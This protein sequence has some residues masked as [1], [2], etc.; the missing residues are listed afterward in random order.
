MRNIWQIYK[1][2]IKRIITNPVALII[3]VGLCI[4]PSLYA[5]FNIYA[6]WDP[7]GNTNGVKVA[8]VNK[9]E[10]GILKEEK[11]NIGNDIVSELK[12]NNDI[13]WIFVDEDEAEYGLTHNKYYASIQIPENFTSDILTITTDEKVKPQLIYKVNE[14]SNAIAPKITSAG[15]KALLK[16]VTATFVDKVN[17][18]IFDAFNT[19][20]EEIDTN[21]SKILSVRD[22]VYKLNDNLDEIENVL[23]KADEGIITFS[24]FAT[25]VN[26]SVPKIK[27]SL[28]EA[29]TV[30][31]NVNTLANTGREDFEKT[32]DLV[33]IK[34]L[35][36]EQFI[37]EFNSMLKEY[38]DNRGESYKIEELIAS[39]NDKVK[40]INTRLDSTISFLEQMN[41]IS[42]KFDNALK[43]LNELKASVV[44]VQEKLDSIS[45]NV[46]AGFDFNSRV[47]EALLNTGNDISN[48]INTRISSF[49]TEVKPLV[50][51]IIS[52]VV[53]VSNSAN[54]LLSSAEKQIPTVEN[55]LA[56]SLDASAKGKSYISEF[57]EK[58]P[59]LKEGIQSLTIKL[60]DVASDENI[61][62]IISILSNDSSVM[63]DFIS[64]PVELVEE[65]V[66]HIPNYGSAM[67][68]FYSILSIWVGVLLLS[69]IITTEVDDLDND[70]K[71]SI[72]QKYFGRML[73]FL[74]LGLIQSL[75]I[76][77]GD[78]YFLGVSME[79]T[80]LF[81]GFSLFT[82]VIFVLILY[83]LVSLL[84]NVGKAVGV[85]LL[86]LQVAGS[87]GTFPIEVTPQFF[88]KL[89]PFLPFT[90]SIGALREAVGGP[91]WESVYR[92]GFIMLIYG[93]VA[94]LLGVVLKRWVNG[95]VEKLQHKFKES[96]LSE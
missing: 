4:L 14:K 19:L 45:N 28:A 86:V 24:E 56:L 93:V 30:S 62:Q 42:G 38:I 21:K 51:E 6:S 39:L 36:V 92:D 64:S 81:I 5:W 69:S 44:S 53:G 91:T 89:Q 35:E 3:I 46:G 71:P 13:G 47:L 75:I 76:S 15:T 77:V 12:N 67:S 59:E 17:G 8:I 10:G 11:L 84:G 90:Y 20:G 72:N 2:D 80:G 87:G 73:L 66:F 95:P 49:K 25:E 83:T 61:N 82:S 31:N 96:G 70:I 48:G 41:K 52:G 54:E 34:L 1:R 63:G 40:A 68:P 79:N 60:R 43:A 26:S 27:E 78:K 85:I 37:D 65:S 18:V 50:D 94:L 32:T 57:R 16:N 58:F 74:T 22:L 55:L 7:Y 23:Q 29:I 9:D 33:E 88:Q